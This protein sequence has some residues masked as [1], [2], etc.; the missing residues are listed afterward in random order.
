MLAHPS[1]CLPNGGDFRMFTEG[2]KVLLPGSDEAATA[3]DA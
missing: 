1:E 3:M 2:V